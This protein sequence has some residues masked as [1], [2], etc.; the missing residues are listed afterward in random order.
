MA[1]RDASHQTFHWFMI[2]KIDG[3]PCKICLHY[4]QWMTS[5][6]VNFKSGLAQRFNYGPADKAT[7]AR[8]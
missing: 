4:I 7:C 8:Q 6:S 1:R 2:E 5:N 3:M